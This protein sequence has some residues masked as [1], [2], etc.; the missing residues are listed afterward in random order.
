MLSIDE[1]NKRTI[2]VFKEPRTGSNW[3]LGNLRACFYRKDFGLNLRE[4]YQF[5]NY[6]SGRK[7]PDRD[8]NIVRYFKNR[9]QQENDNTLIFNTHYF[10]ALESLDNYVDPIVIRTAR[11]NITEKILSDYIARRITS[12]FNVN[13][14]HQFQNFPKVE[15]FYAPI[16]FI[17]Q[18]L[19][20]T[21]TFDQYW[22][23][24][25]R[26]YTNE[27]VYYE[28][29]FQGWES[30]VMPIKWHTTQNIITLKLPYDKREIVLNYDEVDAVCK[31]YSK[32][33]DIIY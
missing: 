9:Y 19:G 16:E 8:D 31:E 28:D 21:R 26:K 22:L 15:P 2:W 17:K 4:L 25:S 23:E 6:L 13:T 7:F 18:L 1:V 29:L 24:W 10:H 3:F 33:F 5:E 20:V 14:E 12:V 32:K 27:V 11:R 30:K